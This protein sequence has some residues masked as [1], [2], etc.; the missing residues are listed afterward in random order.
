MEFQ[1]ASDKLFSLEAYD[2]YKQSMGTA[3][4]AGYVKRMDEI[5]QNPDS[6]LYACI[7]NEQ[8]LG[9]ITVN[10]MSKKAA[11]I[12]DMAFAFEETTGHG[13]TTISFGVPD[14]DAE[15]ERLRALDI[16]FMTEP[17]TYPWGNRS[18]HFRDPDGNIVT[19]VQLRED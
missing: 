17:H 11:A 13:Y 15:Y 5:I 12:S 9:L 7:D 6:R 1:D 8:L 3:T 4:R 14:V 19:L 16:E 10:L 18:V 2:I